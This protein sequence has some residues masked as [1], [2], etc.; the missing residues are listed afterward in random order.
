MQSAKNKDRTST[1]GKLIE[2]AEKIFSQ[3]GYEGA[4]TRMIAQEAESNVSLI[5]RYF[6][7]KYGLLIALVHKKSE[8]F[9][10]EKLDYAPQGSIK[11]ELICYGEFSLKGHLREIN[12]IK[13]CL[14]QFF[15]DTKF[16]KKFRDVMSNQVAHPDVVSRLEKLSLAQNQKIDI[17]KILD[18]IDV[19]SF[20]IL[21]TK[22]L[23]EGKTEKEIHQILI[24][25]I[26]DYSKHIEK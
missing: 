23:V 21:I 17:P 1:E 20:G 19:F 8:E 14:G 10:T 22:F 2:A 15:T 4:T 18:T 3:V 25:F 5:N 26:H 16:L 24:D 12:F 6:D 11:D 7:G 13:V 9:R